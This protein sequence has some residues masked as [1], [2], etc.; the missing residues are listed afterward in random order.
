MRG[1]WV[2]ISDGRSSD[3]R[4]AARD[5]DSVAGTLE[6][7]RTRTS[8]VACE[9]CSEESLASIGPDMDARAEVDLAV[10]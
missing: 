9:G 6:S 5:F 4:I 10:Q 1:F 2:I 7:G 8:S 3:R